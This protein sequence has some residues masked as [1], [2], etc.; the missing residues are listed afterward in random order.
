MV[1]CK[2]AARCTLPYVLASAHQHNAGQLMQAHT[3]LTE[4]EQ[5][6]S[7]LHL[8]EAQVGLTEL[9]QAHFQAYTPP[10]PHVWE[11]DLVCS[12]WERQAERPFPAHALQLLVLPAGAPTSAGVGQ[13][14]TL[15]PSTTRPLRSPASSTLHY[16]C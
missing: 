5:A 14:C 13:V 6:H 1:R 12:S 3:G 7:S 15:P 8:V 4:R 11:E 2:R 16:T 9:T 10:L